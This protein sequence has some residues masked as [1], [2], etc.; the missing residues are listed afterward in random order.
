MAIMTFKKKTQQGFRSSL[1]TLRKSYAQT[2]YWAA[3]MVEEGWSTEEL[4]AE[5]TAN[6]IALRTLHHYAF[7]G[8]RIDPA[9]W[10]R[11]PALFYTFFRVAASAPE[12]FPADR[13]EADP[14]FWLRIASERQLT[15]TALLEFMRN[16]R[17]G[18]PDPGQ[19]PTTATQRAAMHARVTRQAEQ[20]LA[21][22]HRQTARLNS[23]HAP[24]LGIRVTLVSTPYQPEPSSHP[25]SDPALTF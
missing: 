10:Q 18:L 9:L 2:C 13:I 22:L 14:A 8:R 24:H 6:R 11:Y 1:R 4:Q 20:A 23:V 25:T 3:R 15:S 16:R 17:D 21:R 7:V 19:L 5:A 12:W